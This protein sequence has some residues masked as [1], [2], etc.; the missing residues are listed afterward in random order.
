MSVPG[1]IYMKAIPSVTMGYDL[2]KLSTLLD[3]NAS[4]MF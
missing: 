4:Y 1:L 3:Q 2:T